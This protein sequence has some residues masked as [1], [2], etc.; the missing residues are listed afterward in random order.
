MTVIELL[1]MLDEVGR[2]NGP[3]QA[4]SQ[5]TRLEDSRKL[6]P[7]I[8]AAQS[9]SRIRETY[10]REGFI[11]LRQLVPMALAEATRAAAEGVL[12]DTALTDPDNLRCRYKIDPATGRNL[13]D[14]IDPVVDV[15]PEARQVA[16]LPE[17]RGAMNELYGE[18][19]HLFK[20]KLIFKPSGSPGYAWHQDFISW[21]FFPESFA[22][23]MIALDDS[24]EA[25]GCLEI[26]KGSHTRGYLSPRDGD[27]H[28]LPEVGF[29]PEARVKVPLAPGDAVVFGCF[30]VH[31]S[32][33]NR[34]DRTRRHLYLS[35]NKD[36]D[37]GDQRAA[38]YR[39]FHTW[40]KRRYAEYG[41]KN[42][43]FR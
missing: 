15:L 21:P 14:A 35:Y 31:G 30:T 38:H 24:T 1:R 33:P 20:D 28:D 43:F 29:A 39:Y 19:A 32:P 8:A 36:S 40:L 2:S 10:D 16:E 22:T 13:L 41:A 37:G 12:S 7:M 4:P 5:W 11:V 17:L 34:S 9:A 18:R 26:V 23:V 42:A 3:I 25:N 27:F 6:A